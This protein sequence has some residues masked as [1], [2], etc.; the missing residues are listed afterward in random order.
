MLCTPGDN[1]GVCGCVGHQHWPL[2]RPCARWIMAQGDQENGIVWCDE[3]GCHNK[4]ININN[5]NINNDGNNNNDY[6]KIGMIK[7]TTISRHTF[8]YNASTCLIHPHLERTP[9]NYH[10][11]HCSPILLLCRFNVSFYTELEIALKRNKKLF[12]YH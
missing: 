1:G 6:N 5:I 12:F 10:H 9:F 4:N 7:K 11:N 8:D 3:V 2:Q